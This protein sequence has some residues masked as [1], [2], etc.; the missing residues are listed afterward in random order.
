MI[1]RTG[2]SLVQSMFWV[3]L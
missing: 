3:D 1:L 2:I